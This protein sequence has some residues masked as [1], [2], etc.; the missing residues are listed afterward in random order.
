MSYHRGDDGGGLR[1]SLRLWNVETQR[2]IR[3]VMA[4]GE[5]APADQPFVFSPDGHFALCGGESVRLYDLREAGTKQP[6]SFAGLRGWIPVV[7]YAPSGKMIAA[8]GEQGNE[9]MIWDV[10]TLKPVMKWQM[11]GGVSG[12]AVDGKSRHLATANR[13]GTVSFLR[14]QRSEK[15]TE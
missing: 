13:N 11:P 5:A 7:A 2:P 6:I 15:P 3:F 8:V 1:T 12:L 10:G 9:V 14:I 4:P